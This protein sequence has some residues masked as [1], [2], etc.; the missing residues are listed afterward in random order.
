MVYEYRVIDDKAALL[1]EMVTNPESL[2][3]QVLFDTVPGDV[4]LSSASAPGENPSQVEYTDYAMDRSSLS[5][6]T[7]RA[8]FLVVSDLYADGWKAKVDGRMVPIFLANYA[9][10]AVY[11]P[12]GQHQV[13]FS[14]QPVAFSVGKSLSAFGL[15]I[16]IFVGIFEIYRINTK[17]R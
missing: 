8:G 15:V 10:R 7:P 14:Y 9:Y 3:T 2:A 1:K 5:V 17:K 6:N 16:L 13:E 11:L 4:S 12:A